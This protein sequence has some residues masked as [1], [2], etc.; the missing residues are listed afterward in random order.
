M[1]EETNGDPTVPNDQG[2]APTPGKKITVLLFFVGL[3]NLLLGAIGVISCLRLLVS[4]EEQKEMLNLLQK[5]ASAAVSQGQFQ[6]IVGIT[7]V[8]YSVFI[9]IG[10]GILRR[11][12]KIRKFAVYFAIF[13]VVITLIT[14][15]AGGGFSQIS[16]PFTFLFLSWISLM[17]FALTRKE[18]E[19]IFK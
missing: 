8:Y 4:P 13:L 9:L 16:S 18:A 19:L 12:E 2:V 15:V 11:K 6:L 7:C 17:V 3:G 1:D 14:A 10:A 5:V